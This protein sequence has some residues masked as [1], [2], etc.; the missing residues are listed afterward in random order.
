MAGRLKYRII[1]VS[2][3]ITIL[4][5][6]SDCE[7]CPASAPTVSVVSKCPTNKTEWD[8]A[9]SR[10]KCNLMSA[11]C[12]DKTPVYHCLLNQWRNETVEVCTSTWY[13]SGFC[14]V[15]NTD[16]MKVIDDFKT[17]CTKF[18]ED[19]CPTRYLSSDTYLYQKCYMQKNNAEKPI[20]DE[21]TEKTNDCI[22]STIIAIVVTVLVLV[23]VA[24]LVIIKCRFKIPKKAT[25][26]ECMLFCNANK[27]KGEKSEED[28]HVPLIENDNEEKT[29]NQTTCKKT[30]ESSLSGPQV[31]S[32][33]KSKP[34]DKDTN[35]VDYSST[36]GVKDLQAI[37][38]GGKLKS[39][40][41]DKRVTNPFDAKPK[42]VEPKVEHTT[43]NDVN[44]TSRGNLNNE[45]DI[46]I[47]PVADNENAAE[48]DV[49]QKAEHTIQ[50]DVDYHS[51]GNLINEEENDD[52]REK[53][54]DS[55]PRDY[56]MKINSPNTKAKDS[57]A[58]TENA[59]QNEVDQKEVHTVKN[60]VD[61]PSHGNSTNEEKNE[62]EKTQLPD[63][64]SRE[65]V[66]NTTKATTT[67][68]DAA[69]TEKSL[70]NEEKIESPNTTSKDVDTNDGGVY[71][72]SAG[73]V[74]SIKDN[75]EKRSKAG[76]GGE[77]QTPTARKTRSSFGNT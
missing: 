69:G 50:N 10:K 72:Y 17:D 30:A 7:Y 15:Y 49:I 34:T 41:P 53:S 37:Y 55:S 48:K 14:A 4:S 73:T 24:L 21:R 16:E 28:V 2:F 5:S 71:E 76:I 47:D 32:K 43:K 20:T 60:D 12:G 18:S 75:L 64:T 51:H 22:L 33:R 44:I 68:S 29:V 38:A 19:K 36:A 74:K 57:A 63:S 67:D 65:S 23:M 9:A 39:Q 70:Q 11:K 45:E 59:A 52:E 27:Q 6:F 31:E 66:T 58:D 40:T 62:D 3:A 13:I 35:G 8:Q 61:F 54:P 42:E 26:E 77:F 46:D 1:S 25:D 56:D